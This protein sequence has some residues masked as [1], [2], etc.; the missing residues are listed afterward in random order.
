MNDATRGADNIRNDISALTQRYA[1][2][3]R[4]EECGVCLP[5]LNSLYHIN[6]NQNF[7]R[8]K[9]MSTP[10]HFI[11][12]YQVCKRKILTMTG[13]FRM[14]QGYSSSGPLAPFYVFPCGH[15]FHAQCLITHVTSCAH[16][17]QVSLKSWIPSYSHVQY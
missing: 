14:A 4:E 1:V 7:G 17:E 12:Y 13:D 9:I 16:E 15:S 11:V 5:K 6:M 10:I 3:D 2:I 8:S